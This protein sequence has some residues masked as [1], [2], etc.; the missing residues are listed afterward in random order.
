MNNKSIFETL[1]A[2]ESKLQAKL[3]KAREAD[4][5]ASKAKDEALKQVFVKYFSGIETELKDITF[6]RT[7]GHSVEITARGDEYEKQVWDEE[8]EDYVKKT[9]WRTNEVANIKA[10]ESSDWDREKTED[11]FTDL[12]MSVYSS[13]DNYS[14]FM[15]NR[16]MFNG[17][18]AMIIK[19]F[20]DDILAEL[21]KV[22][23]EQSEITNKT[24]KDV[25]DIRDQIDAIQDQ[26]TNFKNDTIIE[27]LK[28][29][30]K[31][32]EDKTAYIQERFDEGTGGIIEA[33]ITRMSYSGKS[34]D[35]AVKTKGRRWD[36]K[37]DAYVDCIY[38]RELTKVRVKNILN[39]FVSGYNGLTW[40]RV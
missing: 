3:E 4:N 35:L 30:I 18:V 28:N 6:G 24:W 29:G 36:D 1:E 34:A 20:K 12:G 8:K 7:Y 22:Y 33:R 32:L 19:D 14:D 10:K 5:V 13:S 37:A 39:A 21:N 25:K 15:V 2:K 11:H 17:Q 27:D 38:D 9:L 16:M 23:K 31:I 26:R 40:E